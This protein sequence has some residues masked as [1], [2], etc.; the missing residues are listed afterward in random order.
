MDSTITSS[1]AFRV[2]WT[3]DDVRDCLERFP[4]VVFA[5]GTLEN[6]RCGFS[7]EVFNI[8]EDSGV[9]YQVFDVS[10]DRS[11]VPALTAFAG[12]KYLPLVYVEG[13]LVTCSETLSE[14]IANGQLVQSI[15]NIA[16]G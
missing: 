1:G 13:K 2:P 4:I 9:S 11:I 16:N 12:R 14:T 3:V 7:K 8:L 5:K 6:P 15:K 10:I